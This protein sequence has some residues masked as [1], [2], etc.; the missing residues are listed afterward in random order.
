MLNPRQ[1]VGLD[2]YVG[3]ELNKKGC[4]V[5]KPYCDISFE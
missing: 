2:F 3:Y 1:I 5:D 4:G